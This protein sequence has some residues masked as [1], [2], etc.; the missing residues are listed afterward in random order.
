[1]FC[2]SFFLRL[3]YLTTRRERDSNPRYTFG[4]YTLSKRA[5]S[6]TRAPLQKMRHPRKTGCKLQKNIHS[7]SIQWAKLQNLSI[8]YY[9]YRDLF[10]LATFFPFS[11]PF[12]SAI[13]ALF[14]TLSTHKVHWHCDG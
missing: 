9:F 3:S 2:I 5:S 10:L 4:V 14:F 12:P 7:R 6:T 1:M 13:Q 8:I 11:I